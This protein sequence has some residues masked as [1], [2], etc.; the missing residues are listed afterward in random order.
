MFSPV[1]CFDF[2][3]LKMETFTTVLFESMHGGLGTVGGP[4]ALNGGPDF[5]NFLATLLLG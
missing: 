5:F 2:V 3:A 1:L 4:R